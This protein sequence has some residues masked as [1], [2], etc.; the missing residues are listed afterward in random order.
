VR[1]APDGLQLRQVGPL[2]ILVVPL[3]LLQSLLPWYRA[4]DARNDEEVEWRGF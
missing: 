3:L 2:C 1:L 4:P